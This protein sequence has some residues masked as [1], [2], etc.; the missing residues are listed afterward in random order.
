MKTLPLDLE[1]SQNW[2]KLCDW[3][4]HSLL[5]IAKIYLRVHQLKS[6]LIPVINTVSPPTK[7]ALRLTNQGFF[8]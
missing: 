1:F 5:R 7:K 4:K 6:P 2:E 3:E 8:R